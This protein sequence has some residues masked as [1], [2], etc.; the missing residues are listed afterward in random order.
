M[1][2]PEALDYLYAQLPAFQREGKKA[3]KPGLKNIEQLCSLN[4]NPEKSLRCLHV[5]GTNGKGSTSH[6]LA[7]MLQEAGF[8][9]GLYTSPHLK[10]FRE[11]IKINGIYI[12]QDWVV[13]FIESYRTQVEEIQPSFFEWTVWMAFTY[14]QEQQVDFAVI[15]VGLGGRLDST[16]VIHPLISIIT[17]IG[18]DHMDVLGDTLVK[19]AR[20]KAGIIK[21]QIPVVIGQASEDILVVFQ[22]KVN[23]EQASIFDVQHHLHWSSWKIQ[24]P[25]IR[26]VGELEDKITQ[27]TWTIETDLTGAYQAENIATAWMAMDVLRERYGISIEP[28]LRIKALKHVKKITNFQGRWQCLGENPLVIADTGH[29]VHAFE[30]HKPVFDGWN[31]GH[32]VLGFVGD[33]DVRAIL[34]LLPKSGQYYFCQIHSPRAMPLHELAQVA[35]EFGL[36]YSLH[37]DVNVCLDYLRKEVPVDG[38]IFVGGST[39]LVAEL[40]QII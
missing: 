22:E 5:A 35:E 37:E 7:A 19:I 40:N 20:E 24:H 17:N 33:K 26:V 36:V 25:P 34:C 1:T 8:R 4:G 30:K 3:I 16:N 10:D 9:V 13:D 29:N 12:P 21:A 14:F 18:W 15:E 28:S 6:A 11:R 23:Q 38:H 31:T 2:Y 32:F 39:F 27:S